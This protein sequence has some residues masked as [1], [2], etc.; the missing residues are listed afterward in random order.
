VLFSDVVGQALI[1][2]WSEK[3]NNK[4]DTPEIKEWGVEKDRPLV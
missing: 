4:H 1:E 3:F 2:D